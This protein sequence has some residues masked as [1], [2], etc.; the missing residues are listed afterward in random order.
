MNFQ[1][2]PLGAHFL[3]VIYFQFYLAN[4]D[5]YY[6][7][8]KKNNNNN[9]NNND[10]DNDNDNDNFKKSSPWHSKNS[11]KGS[12]AMKAMVKFGFP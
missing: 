8:K 9:H 10:N 11:E 2:L 5:Y 7:K 6:L 3:D 1:E 12:G 4:K